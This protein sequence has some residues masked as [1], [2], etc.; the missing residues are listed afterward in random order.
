[1]CGI[2]G[3]IGNDNAFNY[4][5]NGICSLLNRGYDSVGICT[6]NSNTN[7]S[8]NYDNNENITINNFL[9]HKYASTEI[10]LAEKK[11]LQNKY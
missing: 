5:Y 11:I 1:M 2:C 9:L 8:E 3:Y 7:T 10:E 4:I 6:I